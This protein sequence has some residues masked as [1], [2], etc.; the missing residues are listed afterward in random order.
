MILVTGAS[1]FIGSSLVAKLAERHGHENIVAL[2]SKP[3]AEINSVIHKGY[4]DTYLDRS[5]FGFAIETVIHAGSFTPKE[6]TDAN[7]LD[8]CTSNVTSMKSVLKFCE[9]ARVRRLVFLSTIDV[10]GD[11]CESMIETEAPS[12]TSLY[13]T[14]KLFCEK[15]ARSF[16]E[17]QS[18]EINI[19]RV[20]HMYG[21]GEEKYKKIIPETIKRCLSKL[22]IEQIGTGS[23]LRSFIY[24]DDLV[25]AI[26]ST[27][28]VGG[29]PHTINLAGVSTISVGEVLRL[30]NEMVGNRCPMIVSN[31][32]TPRR[33]MVMDVE[34]MRRFLQLSQVDIA[35]GLRSEI[36][37]MR[38]IS[39][40]S[41]SN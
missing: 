2:T 22:P 31:N 7:N 10:Y 9:Q 18:I 11:K 34:R 17:S 16:C 15:A 26:M 27:L 23:D 19:L 5:S 13:G 25:H 21:P 28:I 39:R 8:G 41:G 40:V 38:E 32:D 4:G 24:I 29:L 14:S 6:G 37:Y 20:G 30:I 1:G 12:P 3:I 33:D 36:S 35:D